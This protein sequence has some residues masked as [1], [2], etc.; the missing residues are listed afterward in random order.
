MATFK[1]KLKGFYELQPY[2]V[3]EILLVSSLYDAFIFEE[4]GQLTEKIFSEFTD[5][6]LTYAPR[7]TQVES[8]EKALEMLKNKNYDMLITTLQL[9]D[10]NVIEF[11]RKIKKQYPHISTVLL[12]HAPSRMPE[13]TKE[14]LQ[15]S[16]DGVFSW[17]G[18]TKIFLAIIKLIEDKLNAKHDTEVANVRIILVVEDSVKHYSSFLPLL[19]FE[20]M[21]QTK[22]LISN[23]ITR[24][25]KIFRMRTR[26]KVML[27]TDYEDAIKICDEY[28]DYLIG[29]ISDVRF[30]KDGKTN[31]EAGF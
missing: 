1:P 14:E 3:Q 26:P 19:Y 2:H 24:E 23:S 11:C 31:A 15:K 27:A 21:A 30:P 20:I 9:E 28:K 10:V 13:M 18:N 8:A 5:F 4:D 12:T 22:A 25:N 29:M 16:F 17:N 7:I 6:H